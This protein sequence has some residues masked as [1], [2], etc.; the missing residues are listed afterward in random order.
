MSCPLP[1]GEVSGAPSQGWHQGAAGTACRLGTPPAA[2]LGAG[3]DPPKQGAG[4]ELQPARGCRSPVLQLPLLPAGTAAARP[5][6]TGAGGARGSSSAAQAPQQG[7]HPRETELHQHPPPAA[8]RRRGAGRGCSRDAG[9]CGASSPV[10]LGSPVGGCGPR[11]PQGQ[12]DHS[13]SSASALGTGD[14]TQ[15]LQR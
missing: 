15:G 12:T 14:S 11:G 6:C 8:P 3:G 1:R 13:E 7:P 10:R 5:R 9:E 4:A 2:L